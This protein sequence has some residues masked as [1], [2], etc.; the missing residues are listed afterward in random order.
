MN[1]NFD[2]FNESE[3]NDLVDKFEE[4]LKKRQAFF[5]DVEEYE[6][7][8]DYYV[9][10]DDVKKAELILKNAIE[11][12]PDSFSLL[13]KKAQVFV[14]SDQPEKALKLLNKLEKIEPE[15]SDVFFAKGA[16][17]SQ[18][19]HSEKAIEEYKKAISG[20][21]ALDEVYL[22]IALEY[23]QLKNYTKSI[24]YYTKALD[25]NPDNELALYELSYCYEQAD[26]VKESLRFFT[27]FLDNHPYNRTAWSVLGSAYN[28]DNQIDKAIESFDFAIA[29]DERDPSAYYQKATVYY[30]NKMYNKAIEIYQEILDLKLEYFL[31][32]PYFFLGECYEKMEDYEAALINYNLSLKIDDKNPDAW[33][34]RG[35]CHFELRK[36]NEALL[37]VKKGIS[38]SETDNVSDYKLILAEMLYKENLEGDLELYKEIIDQH[39][40]NTDAWLDYS[41][42]LRDR[43]KLDEA[44]EILEIAVKSYPEKLEFPYR[45]AALLLLSGNTGYAFHVLSDVMNM[46]KTKKN[47]QEFFGYINELELDEHFLDIIEEF[48]RNI[49]NQIQE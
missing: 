26:Q 39:P 23:E 22:N 11:Q 29:I 13:L 10:N 17:Y 32:T 7:L 19:Q 8:I 33:V 48:R 15:N 34:G 42:A 9:E 20:S 37:D 6:T 3:I 16:I 2:D 47:M 38:L 24:E 27:E 44:I 41:D 30:A 1:E 14:Y 35:I 12:H 21:E 49:D 18:L 4:K 45:L 5:F 28:S 31:A 36:I 25:L 43:D 40:D 46:D